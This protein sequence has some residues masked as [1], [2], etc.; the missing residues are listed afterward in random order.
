MWYVLLRSGEGDRMQIGTAEAR[1][2]ELTTGYVEATE[3]P[4]GNAER[5]PVVVADGV[6]DGPTLWVVAAMHADETTGLAVAQDFADWL[7]PADLA[8]QVVCVPNANPAGLRRNSRTSYYHDDDP[9]RYFPAD[10]ADAT[11]PPRVQERIDARLFDLLADS[12]DALVDLHTSW[13][14]SASYVIQPR[15]TYGSN[16]TEAEADALAE[17]LTDL[18]AAFGLPVVNQFDRST[19]SAEG[20]H[21]TLT[22][23]AV[24]QAGIPALTPELGGRY[25]VE[26]DARRLGVEGLKNVA[27]T[28]GIL[29]EQPRTSPQVE[30]PIEPPLKRA[31]HPHAETAG[32]VRYRVDSGDVVN[33]GDPVAD[34]VTP[35]GERKTTVRTDREG[36][37]LSRHEGAAAYEN[38]PLLDLA[39]PDDDPLVV[40]DE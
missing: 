9:N 6:A 14:G 33:V 8:G 32:V 10:D 13:V 28:L 25:L 22:T 23:A 26:E 37:V 30:P 5:I 4:T 2:G 40:P 24:D 12:A 17:E 11:R 27:R 7:R 29:D 16:R 3:L 35:H 36:Y 19:V 18:T 20:L 1:A 39:V 15:V 34:I 38:D 21:R 31:I